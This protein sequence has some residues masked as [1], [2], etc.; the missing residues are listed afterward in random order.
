MAEITNIEITGSTGIEDFMVQ[1]ADVIAK[2]IQAGG[3]TRY[4]KG[5]PLDN[6]KKFDE[7]ATHVAKQLN[8]LIKL[9]ESEYGGSKIGVRVD[10]YSATTLS[11]FLSELAGNIDSLIT[12]KLN[13]SQTL[14][15]AIN[16]AIADAE[17]GDISVE[18]ITLSAYNGDNQL[19]A[20]GALV[21]G[22]NSPDTLGTALEKL[23]TGIKNLNDGTTSAGKAKDFDATTGSI[24]TKFDAIVDANNN[25][26]YAKDYAASGG[27]AT[28]F[29]AIVDANNNAKKAVGYVEGGEIATAL[30]GKQATLT[31]DNAPTENSQNSLKSGAV[32]TALAA[33][34]AALTFDD[35][36]TSGSNNP[37][38]SN[39]IYAAINTAVSGKADTSALS[40]YIATS[41][42]NAASGVCPLDANSKVPSANLPVATEGA[43]GAIKAYVEGTTLYLNF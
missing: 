37:V 3:V 35:T 36:P 23:Y 19:A 34:Q 12:T 20:F 27:I 24:K 40:N 2:G 9:L 14:S 6:R 8:G 32:Y 21:G 39:G 42:K 28:K 17:Q 4:M 33:K 18:T 7:L 1:D 25:A 41:A 15:A 26:K 11:A 30:A 43:Y 5:Q 29:N 13:N 38:K 10:T 31:F 22:T 16:A